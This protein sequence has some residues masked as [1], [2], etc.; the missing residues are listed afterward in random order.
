M[1][2]PQRT[3]RS[4]GRS[5]AH[6][7]DG[8]CAPTWPRLRAWCP[9]QMNQS[10]PLPPR[11]SLESIRTARA[12]SLSTAMHGTLPGTGTQTRSSV[13]GFPFYHAQCGKCGSRGQFPGEHTEVILGPT[14]P[15]A[16]QGRARCFSLPEPSLSWQIGGIQEAIGRIQE[17]RTPGRGRET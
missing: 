2:T 15:R 16:G 11:T 9:R 17:D 14:H 3:R 12:P 1:R 7:T 6:L 5:L 13:C 4:T 10:W 8:C